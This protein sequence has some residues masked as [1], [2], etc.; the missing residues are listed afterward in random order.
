MSASAVRTRIAEPSGSSTFAYRLKIAIPGPIDACARSTGAML[1]CWR[2]RSASGISRLRLATKS[3]RV[4]M[5]ASIE[6]GRQTRT[7]DEASAFVPIETHPCRSLGPHRPRAVD[8]EAG[9][10]AAPRA[11]SPSRSTRS[12]RAIAILVVGLGLLECVVD[13][14]RNGRVRELRMRSRTPRPRPCSK[15]ASAF[16]L[17]PPN[18][19]GVA[20]SSAV[21]GVSSVP[22]R[23]G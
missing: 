6:R 7:I 2:V 5:P 18:R 14:D 22:K 17:S 3:L 12:P 10:R 9:A 1:P 11:S 21:F 23:S 19:Y 15:C 13:G 4:V 20:T 8:R 16:A